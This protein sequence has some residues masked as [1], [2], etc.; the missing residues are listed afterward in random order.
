MIETGIKLKLI[1]EYNKVEIN[2][3][4]IIKSQIGIGHQGIY[5]TT[6]VSHE[7]EKIHC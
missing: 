6:S 2:L 7:Q 3:G 5:Y 1:R 4:T